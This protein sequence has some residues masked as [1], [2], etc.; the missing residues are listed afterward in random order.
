M[1]N[2]FVRHTW[3]PIDDLPEDWQRLAS[4]ELAH[5]ISIWK[6][7]SERLKS[8]DAIKDFNDR[9]SREWAIETGIVEGLYTIDRGTT[10]L[11]IEKGIEESLIAHGTTDKPPQQVAQ[12]IAVQKEALEGVFSFVADQRILSKSYIKQLH[13]VMTQHQST[14]TGIDHLGN[15]V[16]TELIRGDWKKLP[17]NPM[18][19]NSYIHEYCPPEHVES[20]MD[21][22][23]QW[24]EEHRETA[25]AP[26]IEA[27]WLHHRF[28]QIHPFQD[29]NGRIA[30]ALASL[31]FLR[32]RCFPLTIHRDIRDEYIQALEQADKGELQSLVALFAKVQRKAFL[33]A[34]SLSENVLREYQPLQ[35]VVSS[36]IERLHMRREER[37]EDQ[38]LVF[39]H[40][41]SLKTIAEG[42][43]N[44]AAN[45]LTA[46]LRGFDNHYS[47]VCESSN[48]QNGYWFKKQIVD[49][50]NKMKY[51]A[52]TRTYSAWVRLKIREE[53]QTE[54]IIPFHSLG[55]EFVG[56]LVATA[57]IEY[58]DRSEDGDVTID[59]PHCLCEEPFEFSYHDEKQL[60]HNRFRDWL[61]KITLMGLDQWRRQL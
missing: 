45:T 32:E 29:G 9:L 59:G 56:I 28:T 5:L 54:L 24:H 34:L 4:S 49:V 6:E 39:E 1:T 33:T 43:F 23:I 51:Y 11:L 16:E 25:V 12:I 36:A 7:Q 61:T 50:A 40:A 30:R 20:E 13:Q 60:L 14:V 35:A 21:N 55:T 57:F 17:N 58:R 46:S 8:S 41:E 3:A 19:P 48:E 42:H 26:E 27:A 52:D 31:V 18:R 47:A 2:E 37:R 22:L 38:K 15:Y 53:R 10:Q 44:D